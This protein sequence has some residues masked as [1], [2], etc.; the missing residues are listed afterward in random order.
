MK[1]QKCK[2]K[3]C[4]IILHH[5]KGYCKKHYYQFLK[6]GFI[7]IRNKYTKNEIIKYREYAE[8]ILYDN[9]NEEKARTKIDIE[10]VY[11]IKNIRWRLS[12]R[13]YVHSG[14]PNLQLH[15]FLINT[16]KGMLCDHINHDTLDNRKKNIRN[17]TYAQ[18]QMNRKSNG[19]SFHNNR[20]E[21]RL[22]NK[23]KQ[24]YKSFKTKQEAIN[25]REELEIKYFGE[26][27]HGCN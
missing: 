21:V 8:L 6:Y 9:N 20:W 25:Y 2:V 26:F 14:R 15:R 27:R 18:N 23:G 4:N 3:E 13:G 19:F 7:P 1:H 11:K 5:A 16:P 10:D 12:N 17:V 22:K 24:H